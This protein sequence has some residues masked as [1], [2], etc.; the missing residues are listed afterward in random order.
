MV[1]LTGWL[2]SSVIGYGKKKLTGMQGIRPRS[3]RRGL[4]RRA[5]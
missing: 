1:E 5:T 3:L 4:I 2:V